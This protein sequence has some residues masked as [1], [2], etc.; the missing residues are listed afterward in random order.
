M[1]HRTCPL[2]LH[3]WPT[4]PVKT[5]TKIAIFSNILHHFMNSGT[6]L[7]ASCSFLCV[8]SYP[9]VQF[10]AVFGNIDTVRCVL[11][12]FRKLSL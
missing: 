8:F 12:P 5:D 11:A 1:D 6:F 4:S 9:S 2:E 3:S 7:L 10:P